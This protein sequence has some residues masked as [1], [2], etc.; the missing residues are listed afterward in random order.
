MVLRQALRDDDDAMRGAAAWALGKLGDPAAAKD[1]AAA[2][3]AGGFATVVNASAALAR[4]G[5]PDGKDELVALAQHKLGWA[6]ANAALGLGK[7]GGDDA[8]KILVGL[9]ADPDHF[10]RADAARGLGK[11]G[12]AE[13]VLQPMAA[14]DTAEDVRAAATA[15]LAGGPDAPRTDWIHLTGVSDEGG[16]VRR[17]LYRFVTPDGF[18][19]AG[20]TDARG[21]LGEE[22]IATGK[23]DFDWVEADALR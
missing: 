8:R 21:E 9:A 10:V 3:Q 6:R 1:L 11:L 17:A 5:A 16:T 13:A 15:A 2:A 22:Q 7:L 20:Y 4:L 14:K 19:K 23:G 18:V 12:G